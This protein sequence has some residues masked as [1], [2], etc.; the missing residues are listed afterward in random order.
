V[1]DPET[2]RFWREEF[3]SYTKS[4]RS[5]AIAPVLNKVGQIAASPHLRL[6]LEHLAPRLDFHSR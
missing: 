5:D 2:L 1:S 3:P 6:I 4:L